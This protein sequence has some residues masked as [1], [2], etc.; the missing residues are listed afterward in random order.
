M[1]TVFVFF[2][3]FSN[4]SA[5]TSA[6]VIIIHNKCP[7]MCTVYEARSHS[8]SR[9]SPRT[10]VVLALG[11]TM[12]TTYP[13]R[14]VCRSLNAPATCKTIV[15]PES[16]FCFIRF[17]FNTFQT[18]FLPRY[19]GDFETREYK[20]RRFP[21]TNTIDRSDGTCARLKFKRELT[22]DRSCRGIGK[23]TNRF[24]PD[25]HRIG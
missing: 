6:L 9:A 3:Y 24:A 1:K 19:W 11:R 25:T 2:F 7:L 12:M 16:I 17:S 15:F 5:T 10:T 22:H 8:Q 14:T 20:N 4:V 23:Q 18:L 21:C 13:I